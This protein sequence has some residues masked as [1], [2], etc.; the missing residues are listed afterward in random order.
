M[1][2]ITAD[3]TSFRCLAHE[4]VRAKGVGSEGVGEGKEVKRDE[5]AS[6]YPLKSRVWR[7]LIKLFNSE[8]FRGL[9]PRFTLVGTL[10][11]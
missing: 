8:F 5:E 11:G 10:S 9:R 4:G 7:H 1:S 3:F 6:D 2:K